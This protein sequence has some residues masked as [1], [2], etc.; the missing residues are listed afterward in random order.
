M[1]VQNKTIKNKNQQLS[2][3]NLKLEPF[4][5]SNTPINIENFVIEYFNL[6]GISS[7][8]DNIKHKSTDNI[9]RKLEKA[10]S[11][12]K[13]SI[14]ELNLIDKNNQ[15]NIPKISLLPFLIKSELL[16]SRN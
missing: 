15:S 12:R 8:R 4:F 16:I 11:D 6:C 5:I 10:S 14:Q 3:I 9:I 1:I 13:N 7:Q 2:N